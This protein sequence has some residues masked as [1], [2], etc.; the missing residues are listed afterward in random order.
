MALRP[1][2]WA[3]GSRPVIQ[4]NQVAEAGGFLGLGH[5]PVQMVGVLQGSWGLRNDIA[6]V[7]WHCVHT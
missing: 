7:F 5:Q 1:C 4:I 6:M 2:S 3:W